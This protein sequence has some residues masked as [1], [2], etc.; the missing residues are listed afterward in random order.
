MEREQKG[1]PLLVI[2]AKD[3]SGTF[4]V[5]GGAGGKL[6]YLKLRGVKSEA[7]YQNDAKEK[8]EQKQQT[9]EDKASRIHDAK[10]LRGLMYAKRPAA[11]LVQIPVHSATG[12]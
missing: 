9:A 8:A 5:I 4:H 1:V 7:E 3:N 6:N 11:E 10:P 2:P 12:A